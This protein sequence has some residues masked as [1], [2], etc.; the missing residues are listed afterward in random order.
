MNWITSN[1]IWLALGVGALALFA[2]GRGGCGMGH[3]GH[4]HSRRG[5]GGQSDRP[6]EATAGPRSTPATRVSSDST[7][8]PSAGHAHGTLAANQGAL[9]TEHAGHDSA[10]GQG[11]PR[12]HGHGC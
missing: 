8:V 2:F 7:A 12:R 10:S 6:S 9:A 3:G 11:E 1:W 5:E 4:N